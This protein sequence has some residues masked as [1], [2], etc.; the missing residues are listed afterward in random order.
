MPRT[1]AVSE[2][3][4]TASVI[5]RFDRQSV[6]TGGG[7][8]DDLRPRS[9]PVRLGDI[10]RHTDKRDMRG[11]DR[12]WCRRRRERDDRRLVFV[13]LAIELLVDL[14]VDLLLDFGSD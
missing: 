3:H 1:I 13:D 10:P 5:G 8:F 12:F 9:M 6:T 2:K 14:G 7:R 4:D 11:I